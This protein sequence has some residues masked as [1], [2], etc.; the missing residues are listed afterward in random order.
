LA[1]PDADHAQEDAGDVEA[2]SRDYSGEGGIA[3]SVRGDRH[4]NNNGSDNTDSQ[5]DAA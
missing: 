2:E 5:E 1:Q 3:F 4:D